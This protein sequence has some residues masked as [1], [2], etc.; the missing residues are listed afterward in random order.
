M[1]IAHIVPSYKPA[2][3]YGGTIS[4]ISK[5][6]ESLVSNGLDITVLT[7]T[8]NGKEELNVEPGTKQIVD[9]VAVIYFKRIFEQPCIN[10]T[11][12]N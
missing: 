12:N 1:K 7:T 3:T 4:S 11:R 6:C 2:Y 9:G 10:W 8:A 5:L